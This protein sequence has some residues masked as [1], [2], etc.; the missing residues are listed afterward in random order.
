MPTAISL[1][2]RLFS[3]SAVFTIEQLAHSRARLRSSL[4]VLPEQALMLKHADSDPRSQHA[5]MEELAIYFADDTHSWEK[6]RRRTKARRNV[7]RLLMPSVP[8]TA[9]CAVVQ[10][11]SEVVHRAHWRVGFN[12][13]SRSLWKCSSLKVDL[14]IYIIG[15]RRIVF[16]FDGCNYINLL[17][18]MRTK[19]APEKG[20]PRCLLG[21][22]DSSSQGLHR[23]AI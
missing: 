19:T 15:R 21:F 11:S 9:H 4:A 5:I 13:E 1:A 23:L 6:L 2:V 18:T 7:K 12:L 17:S 22:L 10:A 3:I 20:T 14:L 16:L 8:T